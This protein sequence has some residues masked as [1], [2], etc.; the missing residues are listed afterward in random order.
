MVP[1]YIVAVY[2]TRTCVYKVNEVV[3]ISEGA[4]NGSCQAEAHQV[5]M[6]GT[7]PPKK[8]AKIVVTLGPNSIVP[9]RLQTAVYS[10]QGN[11]I[12]HCC[13]DEGVKRLVNAS[14]YS[15][16]SVVQNQASALP[17]AFRNVTDQLAFES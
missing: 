10:K 7:L 2:V 8:I 13:N 11:S 6:K 4:V 1:H 5:I 3:A 17:Q 15:I 12:S 9:C 14:D 16:E